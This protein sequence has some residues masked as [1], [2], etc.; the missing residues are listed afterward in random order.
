MDPTKFVVFTFLRPNAITQFP[1]KL[2]F[3]IHGNRLCTGAFSANSEVTNL[4]VQFHIS[5]SFPTCSLRK[6]LKICMFIHIL[7]A[8]VHK[9]RS[10]QTPENVFHP[11]DKSGT[12]YLF[13]VLKAIQGQ[14]PMVQMI[15]LDM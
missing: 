12:E 1:K 3:F 13:M 2:F 8:D 9:S 14:L 6:G 11:H 15:G 7:S 5:L 4:C 10:E